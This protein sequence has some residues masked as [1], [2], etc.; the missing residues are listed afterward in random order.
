MMVGS[1][2]GDH[3]AS[4]QI[5][6]KTMGVSVASPVTEGNTATKEQ[7]V[8]QIVDESPMPQRVAFI[9]LGA[10]GFGMASWLVQEKFTVCGFDVSTQTSSLASFGSVVSCSTR[11]WILK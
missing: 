8:E 11:T 4:M 5:W 7:T 2:W 10:M 6:D 9:G 3:L 1:Y